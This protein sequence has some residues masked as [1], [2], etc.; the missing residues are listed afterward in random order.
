MAKHERLAIVSVHGHNAGCSAIPSLLH[1]KAQL[2]GAKALLLSLR[3]PENLPDGIEW[4][5]IYNLDYS[6]YS[7]F[8]MHCLASFIDTEFCLVVQDDGCVLNG[9]NWKD[10]YYDYDYIGAPSHCGFS[11]NHI[12]LHF[13][14]AKAKEQVHVVQNGGFSLRS[15][16]F[17]E[18]CNKNGIAHQ[19]GNDVHYWN[20][21]AQLSSLLKPVLEECGMRYAP[22]DVAKEFSIEYLDDVF[23]AT[24]DFK[25]LLGHHAQSRKLIAPMHVKMQITWQ[26]GKQIIGEAKFAEFLQESGYFV[27]W[28]YASHVEKR[29]A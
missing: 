24:T 17:L 1:S 26:Q 12:Y 2:P 29:V 28:K 5:Q 10:E 6:E 22:L 19:N 11:E 3:P 14:W 4:W 13:S 18:V 16:R 8:M 25:K 23:H 21:D 27:E 20:E 15:K 9:E 7:V